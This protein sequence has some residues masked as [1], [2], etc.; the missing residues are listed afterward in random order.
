M[1][2][3]MLDAPEKDNECLENAVISRYYDDLWIRRLTS[4]QEIAGSSPV[5]VIPLKLA[6]RVFTPSA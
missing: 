2:K 1:T 6:K 4:D 5:T 3:T